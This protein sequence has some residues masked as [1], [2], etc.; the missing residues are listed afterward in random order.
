VGVRTPVASPL[1][2]EKNPMIDIGLRF[3]AV[4]QLRVLILLE[5]DQ[6]NAIISLLVQRA[7]GPRPTHQ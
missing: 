4:I 3:Y 6:L 2:I 5:T 7:Y 1:A